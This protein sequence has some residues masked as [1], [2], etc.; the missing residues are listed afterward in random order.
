MDRRSWACKIVDL[1]NL[2]IEWERYV[3]PNQFKML[4]VEQM[5]DILSIAGEKIVDAYNVCALGEQLFTK[6]RA[7]KSRSPGN[8]DATL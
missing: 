6:M 4:V 3:M 8:Q 1:V 2:D 7:N 5:P